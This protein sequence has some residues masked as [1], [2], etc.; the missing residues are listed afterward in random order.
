MPLLPK[1]VEPKPVAILGWG[2]EDLQFYLDWGHG[3]GTIAEELTG[4][5]IPLGTP[6][7]DMRLSRALMEVLEQILEDPRYRERI[8]RHYAM[9]LE[10]LASLENLA[11]VPA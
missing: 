7:K 5:G 4:V 9:D 10:L 6:Q 8:K 2:W 1:V 11:F 3:D